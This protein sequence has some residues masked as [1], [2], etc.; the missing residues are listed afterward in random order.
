M[1]AYLLKK[2]RG[3]LGYSKKRKR[4]RKKHTDLDDL[5]STTS[6][7]L[8]DIRLVIVCVNWSVFLKVN[9][10]YQQR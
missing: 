8:V 10:L 9:A 4:R 2:Q 6:S 1:K 5:V 3:M 7:D